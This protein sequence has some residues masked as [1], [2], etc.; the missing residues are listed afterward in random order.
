VVA[1]TG[2][3][4]A[5]CT[6][7]PGVLA[8]PAGTGLP[9]PAIT[10]GVESAAVPSPRPTARP[11]ATALAA[12]AY[13]GDDAAIATV[14]RDGVTVAVGQ[15]R[16]L[17]DNDPDKLQTLFTPLGSWISARES[18][19]EA[20]TP[21]TCTAEAVELFLDGLR[22]YDD[23]RKDFNA[24]RDWGAHGHPFAPVAPRLAVETFEQAVAALIATCAE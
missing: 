7:N 12:T 1:I 17:D 6:T 14:V 4:A 16:D 18:A 9:A 8:A 13:A 24:W 15:L 2:L 23:I 20:L 10:P 11:S 5:A 21:S 3:L 22:Q 19:I